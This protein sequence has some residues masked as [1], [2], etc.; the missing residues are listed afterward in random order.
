[1]AEQSAIEWTDATWNPVT[2]CTKITS[3]C[4]N[5]YAARFSERFRGV[6][7]HPFEHGFD[8][9]LR[10]E[11]IDHPLRWRRGRMI[12]VNSMSDLFHKAIPTPFIDRVFDTMETA[13]WHTYQVLTKR[14]SRLR[15]QVE[16]I[17]AVCV[18]LT[19]KR[20]AMARLLES[21]DQ[22]RRGLSAGRMVVWQYNLESGA[23]TRSANADEIF[24]KG[25]S[26]E[27]FISRMPDEDA[28]VDRAR[29]EAAFSG[30]DPYY[31]NEF[32]YRH[33]DGRLLWLFNQG[34]VIRGS[35]GSPTDM[36]GVCIDV[37][38]RK[39]AELE[40][41][42]LNQNLEQRISA[43]VS[44]QREVDA[45]YRAYFENTPEALF[46]IGVAPDGSFIVEEIN[47]AHELGLG[48]KLEDIRGKRI[49]EILPE[50]TSRMVL[51]TYQHVVD[52]GSIYQYREQ[53]E[54]DG[55]SKHWDTSIIPL[56]NELGK[57]TRLIGSSRDVTAQVLAEEALRQSQ[58]MDAIG[59]LTGGVAHDFNNLLTPI[60]G[61]LD[62]LKRRGVGSEREQQ[63]MDGAAQSAHRAKTLVQRLLAFA[64]RQPLQAVP[65][66]LRALVE[67]MADLIDSTTG[68][69]VP[70][71]IAGPRNLSS[72]GGRLD[73]QPRSQY[74]HR[75]SNAF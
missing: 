39:E 12:F 65:V 42:A 14:S 66:D 1:M 62:L 20:L 57:I 36:H 69:Q 45:L 53:Y 37:T 32:R 29:I 63:L 47:P 61:A 4:D 73:K 56:H 70:E 3:G 24:G 67:N 35:D 55:T 2:G 46:V 9:T 26:Q 22:L 16:G 68:P 60:V 71:P 75:H 59:Q 17:L 72:A 15:D 19:K 33:P 28:E 41:K 13:D 48:L 43:A 30:A 58:K 38:A 8:L 18:D 21:E 51:E 27:D 49:D 54:F 50:H 64:R 11:R 7:G 52:T 44:A 5:C 31:Q 40:L 6:P 10:P 74:G 25:T 34:Q 23:V